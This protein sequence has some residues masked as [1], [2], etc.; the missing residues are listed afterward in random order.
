MAFEQIIENILSN[1]IKFGQGRPVDITLTQ[2]AGHLRLTIRDRG[3]GIPPA[4]QAQI[5][6]P[7]ETLMARTEGGGFGVGLWVVDRLVTA[8]GGTVELDSAPGDGAEFRVILPL[9]QNQDYHEPS[10]C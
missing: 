2:T 6:A 9:N 1:A 5:F 8:M 4:D 10:Q 7:F 3:P